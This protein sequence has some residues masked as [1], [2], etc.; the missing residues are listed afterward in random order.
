MCF[1]NDVNIRLFCYGMIAFFN[2]VKLETSCR[3]STE[4]IDHRPPNLFMYKI[5]ISTDVKHE[6][7]FVRDQADRDSQ[8]KRDHV[9]AERGQLFVMIKMS[10]LVGFVNHL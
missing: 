10:D 7:V 6:S 4:Y 8:L 5:V 1:G 3:R 9:V 2:S